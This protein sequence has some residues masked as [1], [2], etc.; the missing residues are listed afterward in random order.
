MSE[1]TRT[2]E[3]VARTRVEI[4]FENSPKIVGNGI[5]KTYLVVI[6]FQV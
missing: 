6:H 3:G 2:G 4:F 5:D 1:W